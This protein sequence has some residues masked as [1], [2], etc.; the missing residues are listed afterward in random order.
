MTVSGL[1]FYEVINEW[2]YFSI[3]Y[4][5][6]A[7][8]STEKLIP[9]HLF[10]SSSLLSSP[11]SSS[12]N[13]SSFNFFSYKLRHSH[14]FF[15]MRWYFFLIS[16]YK[17]VIFIDRLIKH[18]KNNREK[19]CDVQA[20]ESSLFFDKSGCVVRCCGECEWI[21]FHQFN[22]SSFAWRRSLFFWVN[23]FLERNKIQT[24]SERCK[25]ASK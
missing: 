13:S 9:Y 5:H 1:F 16:V 3:E 21:L 12:S 24:I 22:S 15:S 23:K 20:Q 2:L 19:K 14:C 10:S 17:I 4:Q 6:D 18:Q 25:W 7:N 11:C 8:F